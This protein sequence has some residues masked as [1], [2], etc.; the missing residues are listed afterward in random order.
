[1]SG[2]VISTFPMGIVYDT[3]PPPSDEDRALMDME[4]IARALKAQDEVQQHGT[5]IATARI[6]TPRPWW[7]RWGR[8]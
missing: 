8:G 5:E 6:V 3:D 7:R 1:M 4:F 2:K